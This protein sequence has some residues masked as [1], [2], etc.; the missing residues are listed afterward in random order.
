MSDTQNSTAENLRQ[1]LVQFISERR[2]ELD[3]HHPAF[4]LYALFLSNQIDM[5]K[6]HNKT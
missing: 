4:S 5:G 6:T 2:D 3:R 1:A